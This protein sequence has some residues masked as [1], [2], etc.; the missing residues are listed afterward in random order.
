MRRGRWTWKLGW[1]I[2]MQW[3]LVNNWRCPI[4]IRRLTGNLDFILPSVPRHFLFSK[5]KAIGETHLLPFCSPRF[6]S[7]SPF[8]GG[9]K[10]S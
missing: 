1:M 6:N 9:V 10:D 2:A 7:S 4:Y 5:Q 3:T 8:Y